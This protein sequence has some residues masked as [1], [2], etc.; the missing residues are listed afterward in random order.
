MNDYKNQIVEYPPLQSG[1]ADKV[2]QLDGD[3]KVYVILDDT[4]DTQEINNINPLLKDNNIF[5]VYDEPIFTYIIG[6]QMEIIEKN[7]IR[8]KINPTDQMCNI[9]N[10]HIWAKLALS[11]QEINSKHNSILNDSH[12]NYLNIESSFLN[13]ENINNTELSNGIIDRIY[14]AGELKINGQEVI[15]NFLS[16]TF[17]NGLINATDPPQEARDCIESFFKKIDPTLSVVIDVSGTT[18][19][20]KE[21]TRPLLNKYVSTVNLNVGVFTNRADASKYNKKNIDLAKLQNIIAQKTR[22]KYK[23]EGQISELTQQYNDLKDNNFGMTK[24]TPESG[25]SRLL[26]HNTKSRRYRKKYNKH[27][28][29]N[30]RYY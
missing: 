2:F 24:Y 29:K 3:D 8:D 11:K 1:I 28:K 17:M 6:T 21:M 7:I 4:Y 10:M 30:K 13:G 15:I 5:G 22:S 9:E 27:S 19:I 14:Y 16:G 26:K 20:N 18:F 12:I 25:G 23:D